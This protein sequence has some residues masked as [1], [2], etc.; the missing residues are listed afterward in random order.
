MHWEELITGNVKYT[1]E[2]LS[3]LYDDLFAI[4]DYLIKLHKPCV[5]KPIPKHKQHKKENGAFVTMGCERY[6]YLDTCCTGCEYLREEGCTV[7]CLECKT[8]LCAHL[9]GK[10]RELVKML[11]MIGAIA[12]KYRF[13]GCY[14]SK[15]HILKEYFGTKG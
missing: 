8:Y 2:Y 13:N 12:H 15:S 6:H 3:D 9:R 14:H 1:K 11:D 5:L 10:H 4:A 7:E